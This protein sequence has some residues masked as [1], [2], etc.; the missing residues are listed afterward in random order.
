MTKSKTNSNPKTMKGV[1]L[2]GNSN[3]E[4]SDFPVPTPSHE[5]VLIKIKASGLCGSDLKFIYHEHIGT[6]GSEYKDVIAGHE[7]CGDIIEI[8]DGVKNFKIGDRVVVYHI[9]GCGNC[10]ECHKGFQIGCTS[11]DRK[12]YGWQRDGGH[13]EYLV[14]DI[15]TLLHLPNNLSY[16]DGAMV[17]CGFGTAFQGL[18]R[19]NVSG[20]DRILIIGMG[21]VGLATTMLASASGAEVIAVDIVSERLNMAKE[22]G[23]SYVVQGREDALEQ[24]LEISK[25]QGVEVAIDCSGSS[26]GRHLCLEASQSWGRV[27]FLGEGGTV[28]FEPS[29]LL[30]RKQ[31]TLYGS[32]V[33]SLEGM[34]KTLDLLSRKNLHPEKIVTHTYSLFNA[35]Q[36]YKMFASGKTGKVMLTMGEC[37][38]KE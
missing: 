37:A 24:I 38:I 8:G 17:A 27:V 21:P 29:P 31:L 23:A 10:I 11:Q 35:E 16:V 2:P 19:A 28:T 30:I 15:S 6:G 36:A 25:G 14:A 13:A 32:W 18:E 5:Q 4:I 22:M 12:A 34:Q 26:S 7:P 20:G 9:S 1:K 3:V 33:C